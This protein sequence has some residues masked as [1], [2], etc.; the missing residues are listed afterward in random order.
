VRPVQHLPVTQRFSVR[1][2]RPPSRPSGLVILLVGA[3]PA[4]R[5]NGTSLHFEKV[6]ASTGEKRM[7]QQDKPNVLLIMT[8]DVSWSAMRCTNPQCFKELLYLREGS[9]QLLTL[10]PDSDD[11]FWQD[12][13]AFAMKPL[14]SKFFW[15]CGE[16]SKTHLVKQWTT[17]GLVLVHRDRKKS[18]RR[19]N[20][21]PPAPAATTQ[22]PRMLPIVPPLSPMADPLH[23]SELL[24]CGESFLA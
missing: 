11:Q 8:D 5:H 6:E 22:A 20:L 3:S 2:D 12:D 4:F 24:V 1:R 23:R 7:A 15:L 10:E 17:S 16:C 14:R 19:P 9:L 18:G 21:I 13:G